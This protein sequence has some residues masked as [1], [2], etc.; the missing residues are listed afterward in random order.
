MTIHRRSPLTALAVGALLLAAGHWPNAASGAPAAGDELDGSFGTGGRV[1]LAVD[2]GAAANAVAVDAT[3]RIVTAGGFAATGNPFEGLSWVVARHLA[4]GQPD[5]S[6][7]GNGYRIDTTYRCS[8][9]GCALSG[10]ARAVLALADGRV[11]VGGDDGNSY[12]VARYLANGALDTA[13]GDGGWVD[14]PYE[15]DATTLV[16]GLAAGPNGS[17]LVLVDRLARGGGRGATYG[18]LRLTAAGEPDAGFGDNGWHNELFS[19][20][21]ARALVALPSGRLL[22]AGY[23][24]YGDSAGSSAQCVV[25]KYWANGAAR[26]DT[27]GQS[28]LALFHYDQVGQYD[29]CLAMAVQTDGKVVVA[30]ENNE[31]LG[32]ARLLSDGT[33]DDAFSA[34]GRLVVPAIGPQDSQGGFG[35]VVDALNRTLV[36]GALYSGVGTSSILMLRLLPSGELDPSFGSGGFVTTVYDTALHNEAYGLALQANGRAVAAGYAQPTDVSARLALVRYLNDGA[37]PSPPPPTATATSPATVSPTDTATTE[38]TA[39]ETSTSTATPT[40]TPSPTATPTA[41]ASGYTVRGRVRLER[42]ASS[43]GAR[44]CLADACATSDADGAFQLAATDR[45]AGLSLVATHPSYLRSERPFDVPAEGATVDVPPVTLLSGDLNQD[46]KVE[47]DDA[48]MVGQR[49]DLRFDPARPG[50]PWLD[51]CDITDDDLIDIRDMVG[52]QF[53]L[54]KTAPSPWR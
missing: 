44:V 5:T 3:G 53:N 39:T 13:F 28:G 8:G 11:V 46:G 48:A 2:G 17:V 20:V 54:L 52:V 27:F 1:A 34:D 36:A 38:P 14:G 32:A 6:F 35:V 12:L 43:A 41:T 29:T 23:N 47:V 16:R 51:A 33:L 25:A 31:H 50:P 7:Y 21:V 37:T 42:R 22:V 19:P 30:G 10:P 24:D 18:L 26:D 15:S 4:T 45:R 49:F 40:I 9:D